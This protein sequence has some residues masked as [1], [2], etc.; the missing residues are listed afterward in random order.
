MSTHTVDRRQAPQA[1]SC[2]AFDRPQANRDWIQ[3]LFEMLLNE[4]LARAR[5]RDWLH[6]AKGR[7]DARVARSARRWGRLAHWA[8]ARS[9]RL[10]W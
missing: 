2:T 7:R 5:I 6:E 4:E 8:A 9:R 1:W 3:E 10:S